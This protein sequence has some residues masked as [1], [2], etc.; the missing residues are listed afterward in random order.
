MNKKIEASSNIERFFKAQAVAIIGASTNPNKLGHVVLSNIKAGGFQGKIYPVN[1]KEKEILGFPVYASINE[2]PGKI[3]L[4]VIVIPAASVPDTLRQS[5]A[6]GAGAAIIISGGFREAGRVDLEKDLLDIA[7]ETGMRLVGPN[8]QGINYIPNKLCASWPIITAPGSMAIISQS[9]T[10]AATIAG[11]AEE[12]N[13]GISATVSLGN[14]IDVNETD[15]IEYFAGDSNIHSIALYLEGAKNGRRFLD[16]AHKMVSTKPLIVLKSGRTFSGQRAA[17][18]HTKSMAGKDE[19]FDAA[20]RQYGIVRA[21]D[22]EGLY[23][24]SKGL[25]SL[26]PGAG[27]RLMII[28]SSGGS[29]ILAV[30]NAEKYRLTIEPLPEVVKEKLKDADIPANATLANPLDLTV[31]TTPEFKNALQVLSDYD[32]A[33]LYLIIFGDPIP[34]AADTSIWLR[35]KIGSKV[36]VAYLGGGEIEKQERK[37]MHQAGIPV[38]ST[39]ERAVNALGA[40]VWAK[41]YQINHRSI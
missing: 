17:A 16:V 1:P 33:D 25:A 39:P 6:K 9:G 27:R 4:A 41:Q 10:V 37:I 40:V 21:G 34:G 31:A 8:C 20:C 28:T 11:W 29:G 24:L 3:D 15:L 23:D 26:K 30:D 32:L 19:I 14:Q 13:W 22:I 36:A 2:I 7:A 5:A 18:S 12:E 38:F 35:D